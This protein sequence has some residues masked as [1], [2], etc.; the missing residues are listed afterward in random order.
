MTGYRQSR[1]SRDGEK[2][3]P[4]I[5]EKGAEGREGYS[6]ESEDF[7]DLDIPEGLIR[8]DLDLPQ[9]SEPEVVRHF[10][11]LSQMN[12]GIDSGM[13]PLGSSTMK[14][15]PKVSEEIASLEGSNYIHPDQPP[16]TVQGALEVMYHLE[17]LLC[18]I[19]GMSRFSFQPSAGA[20]GELLAMLI[21][22]AFHESRGEE[23]TEVIVP[24]SAHGTNPASATMAGYEV[25]ELPSNDRGRIDLEALESAVSDQTAALML[26][27]PNTLGLFEGEIEE[28]VDIVHDAGGLLFYDGANLNGILGKVRPGDMGFD[29]VHLNLHKT[30]ATP[31]GGGG[32]GSGPVGVKEDLEEFL[33]EPL[34]E[35]DEEEEEYYLDGGGEESVDRIRA[36]YGNF[37]VLVKAY[38]YILSMG[39]SGLREVSETAVLNANYIREKLLDVEG[40]EL[41]YGS[42]TPCKHET[43]FSAEPLE[44]E[45]G[46]KASDVS[47]RLLDY[48]FYA[49]TCYFPL[50]VPEALMI[51]P[52]E[53]ES[54]EEIDHFVEAME[55]IAQDAKE[56]PE[57][58]RSAPHR[59]SIGRI[60]KVKASREPILS[61]K[62][63]MKGGSSHARE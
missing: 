52:T 9:L 23:R 8:E 7:G 55:E 1:W 5:F 22:K 18:E 17:N 2:L 43:V 47:K 38:A 36:F 50:I 42:D 12:Y 46:V 28:I 49:P 57:K 4:L 26:T 56:D 10:T 44:S 39:S 45:H 20:H 48:G 3:E 21:V 27:N 34:V 41:K 53:T 63:Y 59:T 16:E 19:T 24:D 14:Y 54:R 58:L 29:L 60:D 61:W 13:Y 62:M 25:V 37:S 32:P 40:Y 15:N 33:P 6:L 51:E 35:F 30:F 11:R 31:H